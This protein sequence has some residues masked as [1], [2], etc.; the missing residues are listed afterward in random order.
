MKHGRIRKEFPYTTH[1]IE[2]PIRIAG[3][4]CRGL[5]DTGASLSYIPLCTAY[6]CGL[7]NGDIQ[8]SG[9]TIRADSEVYR[10]VPCTA[11]LEILQEK[12]EESIIEIDR[13]KMSVIITGRLAGETS[14]AES[15]RKRAAQEE[16]EIDEADELVLLGLDLLR[17]G[18]F[19]L[20]RHGQALVMTLEL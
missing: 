3:Y 4:E 11:K 2:V 13:F 7:L 12:N 19:S 14:P 16:R 10:A 8:F 9:N 5:I 18:G 1:S 20:S 15:I 17:C 6:R